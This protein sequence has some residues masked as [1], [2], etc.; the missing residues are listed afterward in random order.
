[1]KSTRTILAATLLSALLSLGFVTQGSWTTQGA[2][3]A[4]GQAVAGSFVAVADSDFSAALQ[5]R[6]PYNYASDTPGVDT[7]SYT[8]Y[9]VTTAGGS[10]PFASCTNMSTTGDQ[11]TNFRCFWA[12]MP[13]DTCLY[14]P[15]G[16]YNFTTSPDFDH[17][18]YWS[19]NDDHRCV[20]G[21]SLST[22]LQFG[23]TYP[24]DEI[25]NSF[26][27]DNSGGTVW[28]AAA[29]T[30]SS[31]F[32]RGTTDIVVSDASSFA[33][34]GWIFL[35]ADPL[36]TQTPP[37]ME[38]YAKVTNI[39]G[40]TITIDRPL[41]D[42]FSGG[43]QLARRWLPAEAISLENLTLTYAQPSH[44]QNGQATMLWIR[45]TAES[46]FK[47]LHL[48]DVYQY[49]LLI[50]E[51]S[52]NRIQNVTIN[53]VTD[54][55]FN[56]YALALAGGSNNLF[57]DF[58]LY[59]SP[60]AI[61]CGGNSQGNVFAFFSIMNPEDNQP[62]FDRVCN[63]GDGNDCNIV[64]HS[65]HGTTVGTAYLHCS[66][67]E[68]DALGGAGPANSCRGTRTDQVSGSLLFHGES[69]SNSSFIRGYMEAGIWHDFVNGGGNN[70]F[71]FG[72][73]IVGPGSDPSPVGAG[74]SNLGDVGWKEAG[75]PQSGNHRTNW[76][77]VNNSVLNFGTGDAGAFDIWMD[78]ARFE[79]NVVRGACY[80]DGGAT[81]ES[82]PQTA[83]TSASLGN[84]DVS[85]S[86]T[87]NQNDVGVGASAR[88]FSDVM[89]TAPGFTSAIESE[90]T[91]GSGTFPWYGADMGGNG[92]VGTN[93]N[94]AYMR[95]YGSC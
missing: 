61:S 60:Q 51:A 58:V 13:E 44:Q 4:A 10:A 92:G 68:N 27:G 64:D 49:G 40:T 69:C 87:W 39:A 55:N 23:G 26:A 7:S 29:V 41:P 22:I 72:V 37:S 86:V 15:N 94:P 89:P 88:S 38:Y 12:N 20:R 59:N 67:N 54:K 3:T 42:D 6:L 48:D 16:T 32:S 57:L 17:V 84:G 78:D 63:S 14:V 21:Q 77:F 11:T 75:N 47:N 18:L 8:E 34:G 66:Q 81:P 56:N 79:Y 95:Y 82:A 65:S 50:E 5:A 93:C 91:G 28:G 74:V 70:N 73:S 76:I 25:V 85:G 52:R 36:S 2:F 35:D 53:A 62:A 30:W 45:H 43:S 9:N 46:T 24:D 1:M 71:V 33:V 19:R 90:L 31:G 80:Y 83:C